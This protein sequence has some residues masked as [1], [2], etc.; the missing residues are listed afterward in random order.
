MPL[1]AFASRI[2]PARLCTRACC[3]AGSWKSRTSLGGNL[4]VWYSGDDDAGVDGA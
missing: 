2:L 1:L 4:E 3:D